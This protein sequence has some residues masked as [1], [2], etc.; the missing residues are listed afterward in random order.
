MQLGLWQRNFPYVRVSRNPSAVERFSSSLAIGFS[1]G[2]RNEHRDTIENTSA[3]L[4]STGKV[5]FARIL[6]HT[7]RKS[8]DLPGAP[9]ILLA[10]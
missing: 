1:S 5:R 4:L 2:H 6:P 8:V 9:A 3:R 7:S 10:E